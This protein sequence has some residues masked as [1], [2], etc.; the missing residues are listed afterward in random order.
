MTTTYKKNMVASVKARLTNIAKEQMRPFDSVLLLYMQE[1]LLHR[2]SVSEYADNFILKGGLLMFILTQYKGRPTTDIDFLAF[3][4]DND[5]VN[6]KTIFQEICM[7]DNLD[8]GL[9]FNADSIAV[10]RIKEV[11]D[12]QGFRLK[13]ICYLG[14]AKKSLQLDIGFGDII[15]PNPKLMSF[16][17]LLDIGT[18]NI[19]VYSIESVI[20]EKFHAMIV[21]SVVNSRMKDFY[22]VYSLL[23]INRFDG[24][25]LRSSIFE[26]LKRRNTSL[27][28]ELAIFEPAFSED[29]KRNTIWKAFLKKINIS[30]LSFS[31]V[32]EE[33]TVFLKPVYSAILNDEHFF[34]TWDCDKRIW[35][36]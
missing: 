6:I 28:N 3:Q 8:D 20:A 5:I 7:V 16:P 25:K 18:S 26:T 13:I 17:S 27:P 21:L 11:T 36:D 35:K 22:D 24:E 12:Y 15:V 19:R 14:S 34:K 10:E 23:D 4:I 32:M 30:D 1:R 29:I 33:L 2:L 31:K 9:L